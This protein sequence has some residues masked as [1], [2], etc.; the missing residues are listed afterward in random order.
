MQ[1]NLVIVLFFYQNNIA[2]KSMRLA[3]LVVVLSLDL[4]GE[5]DGGR[6]GGK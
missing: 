5:K 4:T 6:I 1:L 2:K 3:E